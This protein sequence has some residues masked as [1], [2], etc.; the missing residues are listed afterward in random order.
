MKKRIFL[1]AICLQHPINL[2]AQVEMKRSGAYL[3][4][5]DIR[6]SSSQSGKPLT[7]P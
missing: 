6:G 7:S 2:E 5:A 4:R 1:K 3:I